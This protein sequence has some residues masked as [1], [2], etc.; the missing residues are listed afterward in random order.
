MMNITAICIPRSPLIVCIGWGGTRQTHEEFRLAADIAVAPI[1]VDI[2]IVNGGSQSIRK[3]NQ[4][5]Q[6]ARRRRG[7]R[8]SRSTTAAAAMA[9]AT[10]AGTNRG[11]SRPARWLCGTYYYVSAHWIA[12]SDLHNALG[13]R[14]SCLYICVFC[15]TQKARVLLLFCVFAFCKK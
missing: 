1:H 6:L 9:N 12:V 5:T 15:V 8:R 14:N 10:A 4:R 13:G 3:T 7:D 2:G 11:R